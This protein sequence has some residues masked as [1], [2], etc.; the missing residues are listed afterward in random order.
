MLIQ[1]GVNLK[2][3]PFYR[4]HK[5]GTSNVG[6]NQVKIGRSALP[7]LQMQEHDTERYQQQQ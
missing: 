3:L 5:L 7:L 4:K 1:N 6:I 2:P